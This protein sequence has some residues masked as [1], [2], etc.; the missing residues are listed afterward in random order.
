[1]SCFARFLKN[2]KTVPLYS[3]NREIDCL[4]GPTISFTALNDSN[5]P[6]NAV[7]AGVGRAEITFANTSRTLAKT[8]IVG[9]IMFSPK[10]AET[11]TNCETAG[12]RAL[13]IFET[14]SKIDF[15]GP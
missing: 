7:K 4:I 6:I 9:T 10:I 14:E 12:A 3:L 13:A 11:S 8:S 5:A 1:M 2:S 15:S